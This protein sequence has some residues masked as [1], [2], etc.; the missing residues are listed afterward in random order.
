MRGGV[1]HEW[2]IDVLEN[3]FQRRG[4]R[5]QRQV[6]SRKGRTTGY[7]DL[8]VSDG[9]LRLLVVEV[10]MEHKRAAR[11]GCR[12]QR[13]GF[14]FAVWDSR[15]ASFDLRPL[16][17]QGVGQKWERKRKPRKRKG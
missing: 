16:L 12:G 10:E 6:P 4:S 17:F 13:E 14:C 5:T 7:I 9:G 1:F 15:K 8:L 3:A 11:S 2:K